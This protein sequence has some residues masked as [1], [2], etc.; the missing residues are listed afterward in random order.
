VLAHGLLIAQVVKGCGSH[1]GQIF[2]NLIEQ[3]VGGCPKRG[4]RDA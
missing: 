2:E 4:L 3:A 1:A